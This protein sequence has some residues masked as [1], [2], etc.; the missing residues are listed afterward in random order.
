MKKNM[1]INGHCT[2]KQCLVIEYM[3]M[4]IQMKV[5]KEK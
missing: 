3:T 5:L 1:K 2:Y 4:L